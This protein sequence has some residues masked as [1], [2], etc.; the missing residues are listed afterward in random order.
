[1]WLERWGRGGRLTNGAGGGPGA[2]AEERQQRRALEPG[3]PR[4]PRIRGCALIPATRNRGVRYR[5]RDGRRAWR[6]RRHDRGRTALCGSRLGGRRAG[7]CR[8]REQDRG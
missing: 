2:T 5:G 8:T 4:R 3:P 1:G 7:C 6:Q